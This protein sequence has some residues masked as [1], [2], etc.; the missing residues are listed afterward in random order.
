MTFPKWAQVIRKAEAISRWIDDTFFPVPASYDKRYS[1]LEEK[2]K[3]QELAERD[4]NA[5]YNN[6]SACTKFYH[7][8]NVSQMIVKFLENH[9]NTVQVVQHAESMRMELRNKTIEIENSQK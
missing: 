6:I 7:T 3:A 1:A 8:L 2:Q 9:G 4:A 5:I